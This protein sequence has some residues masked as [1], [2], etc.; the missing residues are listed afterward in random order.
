MYLCTNPASSFWRAYAFLIITVVTP[1]SNYGKEKHYLILSE[2][3]A[4]TPR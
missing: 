1:D 3:S 4:D 2:I